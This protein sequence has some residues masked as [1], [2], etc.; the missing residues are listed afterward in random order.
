MPGRGLPSPRGTLSSAVLAVQSTVRTVGSA[1]ALWSP[2]H[3][4][5]PWDPL[6]VHL[7]VPCWCVQGPRSEASEAQGQQ[8]EYA[9]CCEVLETIYR[10][11]CWELQ[12]TTY[13]S[14][15]LPGKVFLPLTKLSP[16][17]Q[18]GFPGNAS[19]ETWFWGEQILHR[20]GQCQPQSA[21]ATRR[22]FALDSVTIFGPW[23]QGRHFFPCSVEATRHARFQ[24][25]LWGEGHNIWGC[26]WPCQT[27]GP[28]AHRKSQAGP[29]AAA[30]WGPFSAPSIAGNETSVLQQPLYLQRGTSGP[31]HGS[32]WLGHFLSPWGPGLLQG[33]DRG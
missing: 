18:L 30:C 7:A 12:P 8:T 9:L 5:F 27:F 32:S 11:T 31:A 21:V 23:F 24:P 2:A 22:R 1:P 10:L 4:C 6:F 16:C 3:V 26:R 29:M 14:A 33:Q 13:G 17:P 20:R 19:W 25:C 15:A 28:D